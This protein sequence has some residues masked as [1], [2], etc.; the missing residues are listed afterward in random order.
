M[1]DN[2]YICDGVL[3]N[4]SGDCWFT[5][6]LSYCCVFCQCGEPHCEF[7]TH[8]AHPFKN[9][10]QNVSSQKI[11][12]QQYRV[13]GWH[14][15]FHHMVLF[16]SERVCVVTSVSCRVAFVPPIIDAGMP[17]DLPLEIDREN[18][19]EKIGS[20]LHIVQ[21][22]SAMIQCSIFADTG[23]PIDSVDY[24]WYYMGMQ[25]TNGS[26][27]MITVDDSRRS[28]TLMVNNFQRADNGQFTCV[29]F[30]PAGQSQESTE[31]FGEC[32]TYMDIIMQTR[33]HTCTHTL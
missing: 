10:L 3:V 9:N 25:I 32:Y 15:F 18:M 26:K 1:H 4:I 33:T 6:F 27:F 2:N 30:N 31:V 29:A 7:L 23:L 14:L 28:S 19:N 24:T 22:Q 17:S 5:K 12:I 11:Y 21:G 20:T 13:V 16:T 8:S